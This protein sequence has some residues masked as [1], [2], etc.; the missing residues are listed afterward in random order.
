MSAKK[1]STY[2]VTTVIRNSEGRIAFRVKEFQMR[3]VGPGAVEI[4]SFSKLSGFSIAVR[5][6]DFVFLSELGK[7]EEREK[8][9]IEQGG[10][11]NT[12]S[13]GSVCC[14]HQ[15]PHSIMVDGENYIKEWR[16]MCA[17]NAP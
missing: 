7:D 8:V 15:Q 3:A 1:S 2:V 14:L 4:T 12:I 6:G 17:L 5:A 10:S 11:K 16:E 13:E 9:I